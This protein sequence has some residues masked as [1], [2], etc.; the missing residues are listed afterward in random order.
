MSNWLMRRGGYRCVY[1]LF[2]L[3][4]SANPMNRARRLKRR[5]R[6]PVHT[7]NCLVAW[8]ANIGLRVRLV[9]GLLILLVLHVSQGLCFHIILRVIMIA[10]IIVRKSQ[11]TI[12]RGQNSAAKMLLVLLLLSK[13]HLGLVILKDFIWFAVNAPDRCFRIAEWR[14]VL[15]TPDRIWIPILQIRTVDSGPAPWVL[16][17]T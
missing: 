7:Q 2:L 9:Q 6:V 13:K 8:P 10:L 1:F 3:L 5:H 12:W 14:L 11:T 17:I 16:I 15:S 4:V